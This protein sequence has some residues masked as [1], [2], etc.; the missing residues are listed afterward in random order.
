MTLGP[1]G[2]RPPTDF[3]HVSR[4]PLTEPRRV[5]VTTPTPVVIGVNWYVEF[6]EPS[7]T[8]ERGR[9][10]YW[11]ARDGKLSTVRG[12]HCVCLKPK[13]VDDLDGWWSF[14]D[15]GSE[16]AC[17]GYGISRL[18]S[19]LNR[20][21]YDASWLYHEA[22][23][24]DE[25][26]GEGYDGTSVRAGLDVLRTSG[27]RRVSRN[28][29]VKP[30]STEDGIQAN[31]WA[32]SIDDVLAVL[33]SPERDYV[34]FLNSWGRDGYPHVVRMPATVLERLRLEDGEL[35]VVTDR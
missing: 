15:Q 34:E 14:Y 7:R 8:R 19:L 12:G 29:N 13:G 35:G 11:V 27:H 3:S 1:L 6:D 17:V 4:Y 31:R 10:V 22:Q 30:P 5:G 21:R 23:R 9:D 24:V 20:V 18:A 25:W 16:G 28:G 33:G 32:T 26:P 2:R